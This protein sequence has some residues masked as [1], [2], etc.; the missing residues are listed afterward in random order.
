MKQLLLTIAALFVVAAATAQ[1]PQQTPTLDQTQPLPVIY[2]S[3]TTH[4]AVAPTYKGAGLEK[5]WKW[6]INTIVYPPQLQANRV[7]GSVKIR[8]VVDTDGKVLIG[9]VLES[10]REEF[11]EAVVAAM[12]RSSKWKPG[13]ILDEETGEPKAVKV[14]YTLL[15]PFQPRPENVDHSDATLNRFVEVKDLKPFG[16]RN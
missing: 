10:T 9:D 15:I 13:M 3:V 14:L 5:Y 11:T 2:D 8:F 4:F 7:A 1:Q 6:L 12:R 16:S